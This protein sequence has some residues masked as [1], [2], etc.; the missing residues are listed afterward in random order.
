[1]N[2]III[3]KHSQGQ[4]LDNF[5]IKK[6]ENNSKNFIHK[7]IRTGQVRVNSK[8]KTFFYKLLENDLIRIPPQSVLKAANKTS[9]NKQ[10]VEKIQQSIIYQDSGLLIINKPSGI[11]VHSGTSRKVGIIEILRNIYGEKLELI[12]RLDVQTSGC[13]LI[14]KKRLI[15]RELHRQLEQRLINKYYIALLQNSWSK[16]KHIVD[17]PLK[18][19]TYGKVEYVQIDDN[20]KK[21][22][23]IFIPKHNYSYKSQS[24]CLADIKTITGRMHQ[25][26]VHAQYIGHPVIGDDKY[27]SDKKICTIKTN[28]LFLHAH[29]IKFYNPTTEKIQSITAPLT[30]DLQNILSKITS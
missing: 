21:A 4:R 28:R 29:S 5:L 15:M 20:G 7:I 30:Q 13:L 23:T 9:I 12:H 17:K 8:R 24:F 10:I 14:S 19:N 1:M 16:Q 11:A 26:R 2:K 22:T 25:I 18:K 27:N 3:D 6:L